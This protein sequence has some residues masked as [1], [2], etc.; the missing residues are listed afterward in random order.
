[1]EV[2]LAGAVGFEVLRVLVGVAG[3]DAGAVV[4]GEEE[5]KVGGEVGVFEHEVYG[6]V[7]PPFEL[8]WGGLV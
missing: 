3:E 8:V 6:V 4:E 7:G 1:M 2:G 5:L